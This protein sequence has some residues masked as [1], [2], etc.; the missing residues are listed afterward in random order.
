[1]TEKYI[2]Y[3]GGILL[4]LFSGGSF[5]HAIRTRLLDIKAKR[6]FAALCFALLF[7]LGAHIPA[8]A[9]KAP[10]PVKVIFDT[11][12]GNDVDDALAL[13]MLNTLQ[14]DGKCE[15]LAITLTIP[16]KLAAPYTKAINEAYGHPNIPIGINPNS[17]AQGFRAERDFLSLAAGTH[18]PRGGFDA[19]N[20]PSALRLLRKTLADA[21]PGSVV[22]VQVGMFTNLADLL[23]SGPDDISPKDGMTLAREKV[24]FLSLMAGNFKDQKYAEF[25][26]KLDVPSAQ[27]VAE[28][29]PTARVWSGFEIGKAVLFPAKCIDETLP[30]GH[31]IRESYQRYIPT[32][33][34]RPCWDL[35]SAWLGVFPDTPLFGKSEKGRVK[36][37]G[38]GVTEFAADAAGPDVYLTMTKEQSDSLKAKFAEL[39]S[40]KHAA[41]NTK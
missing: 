37:V 7:G 25:N 33:H 21:K 13:A 40:R 31:I 34:Q 23:K 38:K 12:M 11:D 4:A 27:Y 15:I 10:A 29:W 3:N 20:A 24:K 17:P 1:M 30:A 19:A 32:P 8:V 2:I 26:V 22:I 28:N 35:T 6:C 18:A 9:A 14:D 36:V 41:G 5:I 16:H 39:I